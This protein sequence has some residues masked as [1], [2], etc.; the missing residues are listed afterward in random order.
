MTPKDKPK[1]KPRRRLYLWLTILIFIVISGF[2]IAP[3]AEDRLIAWLD[4]DPFTSICDAGHLELVFSQEGVSQV[5]R[6]DGTVIGSPQ[7]SSPVYFTPETD[8]I[9]LSNRSDTLTL[10]NKN[11]DEEIYSFRYLR[12][13]AFSSDGYLYYMRMLAV[14]D[15]TQLYRYNLQT[16][17]EEPVGSVVRDLSRILGLS[18]DERYIFVVEY[19]ADPE[20]L[21][22]VRY[23]T[24]TMEARIM[25]TVPTQSY[26]S[27][28][29]VDIGNIGYNY[30]GYWSPD[31]RYMHYRVYSPSD[32][33]M[34][35]WWLLDLTNP[36]AH[37]ERLFSHSVYPIKWSPDN[38][39]FAYALEGQIYIYD[40]ETR[41]NIASYERNEE[42]L[43][44]ID[45]RPEGILI[46]RLYST[47]GDSTSF[48][49][50]YGLQFIDGEWFT[51]TLFEADTAISHT[52]LNGYLAFHDYSQESYQNMQ[53]LHS[54][55]RNWQGKTV[56]TVP[57]L[58]YFSST[59]DER[60]AAY[61]A[62]NNWLYLLDLETLNQCRLIETP[63]IRFAYWRIIS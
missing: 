32:E 47:G 56:M 18:P 4:D 48:D 62:P 21:Q 49:A 37:P 19:A 53:L 51:Q 29:Q 13:Y 9:L 10:I 7:P 31:G 5:V 25:Q 60:Y 35:G 34:A 43:F 8:L 15:D 63:E 61:Y 42:D 30:H 59:A 17:E 12:G 58:T 50:Y 27:I 38:R 26:T 33:D 2:F 46:G 45:W 41:Q 14:S 24:A 16:S 3:Y 39:H 6:G 11:T 57:N 23:D 55:L 28:A 54:E 36:G 22:I 52:I 1:R 44:V 40:I 20:I